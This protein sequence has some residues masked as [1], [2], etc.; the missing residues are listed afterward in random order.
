[1]TA[2]NNKLRTFEFKVMHAANY[3]LTY[4]RTLDEDTGQNVKDIANLTGTLHDSIRNSSL[5][6]NS[7]EADLLGTQAAL[8]KQVRYSAAIREI[9]MAII[10][11]KFGL[12]QLQE[13]LDVIS[14]GN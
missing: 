1:L 9:E 13:S 2:V 14:T 7:I 11:L 5:H 6:L 8:E 12:I 4:I 10:E 3:Q